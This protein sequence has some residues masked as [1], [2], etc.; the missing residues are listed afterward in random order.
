VRKGRREEFKDFAWNEVPDPQDAETFERSKLDWSKAQGENPALDWYKALIKLRKDLVWPGER[1]CSSSVVGDVIT[2]RVPAREPR[3]CV[4]A[5]LTGPKIP[6][7]DAG[8]TVVLSAAD[9][10]GAVTVAT[11]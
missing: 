2:M 5:N 1:S 10:R 11:R 9:E 4:V 3:V 7:V 8:W 6:A